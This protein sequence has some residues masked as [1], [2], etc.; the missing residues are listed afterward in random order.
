M[1]VLI[2]LFFMF[3]SFSALADESAQGFFGFFGA[4]ELFFNDIYI[5]ITV[6]IPEKILA[7]VFWLK[8]YLAF[9]KFYFML[10]L[11]KFSHAIAI[12]FMAQLDI[13]GVIDAAVSNL[14]PDLRKAAI[15]MRVFESLNLLIEALITRFVYSVVTH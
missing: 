11:L 5:F 3:V 10:E 13:T 15:D 9:N 12:D 1:R 7:F 8:L 14:P 6:V 4:V 2:F